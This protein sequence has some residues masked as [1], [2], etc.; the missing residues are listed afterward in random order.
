MQDPQHRSLGCLVQPRWVNSRDTLA[1]RGMFGAYASIAVAAGNH[2]MTCT[3]E[4]GLRIVL[5]IEKQ[6]TCCHFHGSEMVT[7]TSY[8]LY[9]LP[10]VPLT[11]HSMQFT[12]NAGR[13]AY[14]H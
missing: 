1:G 5:W 2:W 6:W 4:K 7:W 3:P 11:G 9:P 8:Y 12:H 14:R 13:W 10:D